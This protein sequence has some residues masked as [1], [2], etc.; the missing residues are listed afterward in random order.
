MFLQSILENGIDILVCK[1]IANF[2]KILI[3]TLLRVSLL[4]KTALYNGRVIIIIAGLILSLGCIFSDTIFIYNPFY[5]K[6]QTKKIYQFPNFD[7][8]KCTFCMEP[9]SPLVPG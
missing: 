2:P 9:L 5:H 8:D 3:F 4:R 7:N 1:I 6:T